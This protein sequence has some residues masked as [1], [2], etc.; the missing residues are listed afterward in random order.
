MTYSKIDKK[1]FESNVIIHENN[2]KSKISSWFESINQDPNS[3]DNIV[4][5]LF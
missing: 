4:E 3:I 2:Y 1:S 5:E